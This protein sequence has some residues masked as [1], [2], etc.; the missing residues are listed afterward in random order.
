MRILGIETS[1]DESSVAYLDIRSGQ[2]RRSVHLV[3][4]QEIHRK[5]GG[6]VPEVAAREHA[7]TLPPLLFELAE[8]VTGE[9]DG[10]Q[11]GRLVDLIAATRGPGLVT[12]LRVGLDTART[13]AAAWG[14]RIVGVNHIEAHVCSGF[15]PASGEGPLPR[16]RGLFPALVLVVSGGHTE[17]LLMSGHRR[18]RLLGA[19]KDDAAGEA[20]DKTAKLMGLGY[21]GGPAISALARKGNPRTFEFPRPLIHRSDHDFSFSGLKTAVRYF[22]RDR[23]EN[24]DDER[25]LADVAASVEQ[26]IVDVLVTKTLRAARA[27]RVRTVMLAGGVAAN[28]KLRQELKEQVAAGPLK[29]RY[30]EPPLDYCTDNAMMVAL[31]A[32]Y[33]LRPWSRGDSWVGME[34]DPSWEL[35]R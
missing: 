12:S 32:Y 3:S 18:F 16:G 13:L 5:Y 4:T 21:P 31:A 17:L 29:M 19:T 9:A 1:C 2:V 15:L 14:K 27:E 22:L 26:A 8:R 20:F 23:Q 34:A 25:F 28:R 30:V 33:R 10:R 7:V 6:V 35:G 11:L 24:L